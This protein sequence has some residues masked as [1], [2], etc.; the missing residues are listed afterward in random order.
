MQLRFENCS[1]LDEVKIH[2]TLPVLIA[3]R[4]TDY[5]NQE[6]FF[7]MMYTDNGGGHNRKET[8]LLLKFSMVSILLIVLSEFG[9]DI[10][11]THI[12]IVMLFIR[13]N[14]HRVV[15]IQMQ[16]KKLK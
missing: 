10:H 11:I 9:I 3:W 7:D 15:S 8:T 1:L 14:S 16:K 6:Y 12:S 2:Y 13:G 4:E 5:Q